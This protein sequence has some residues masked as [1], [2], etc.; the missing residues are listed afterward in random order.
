MCH[1]NGFR[2]LYAVDIVV[3]VIKA[4]RPAEYMGGLLG[5]YIHIL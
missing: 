4:N 3:L 2:G 1:I 5:W